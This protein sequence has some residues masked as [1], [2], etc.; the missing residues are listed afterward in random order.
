[1]S[2]PFDANNVYTLSHLPHPPHLHPSTEP[3]MTPAQ[4]II[5]SM[6]GLFQASEVATIELLKAVAA[7]SIPQSW[8]VVDLIQQTASL[9]HNTAHL[10]LVDD[11]LFV[12]KAQAI[13]EF[14]IECKSL[15]RAFKLDVK[16]ADGEYHSVG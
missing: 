14:C 8:H 6:Y 2:F 7:L 4:V 3:K 15:L 9:M 16:S 11:L 10:S 5:N 13:V 1:M 12:R